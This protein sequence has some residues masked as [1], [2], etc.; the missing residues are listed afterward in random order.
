MR[1]TVDTN[2]LLRAAVLDDPEQSK[3]AADLL[4]DAA[5]IAVPLLALCEFAYAPHARLSAENAAA[6]QPISS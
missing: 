6:G 5:M 2:V 4:T 3:V 1:V